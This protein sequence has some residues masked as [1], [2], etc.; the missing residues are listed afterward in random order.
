MT[1]K[2]VSTPMPMTKGALSS[3]A[4]YRS[5]IL[6]IRWAN[7]AGHPAQ[8]GPWL[9]RPHEV[10]G[11]EGRSS[12]L[13]PAADKRPK[14]ERRHRRTPR[15]HGDD[16]QGGSHDGAHQLDSPDGGHTREGSKREPAPS[17]P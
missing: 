17:E 2:K 15:S 10:W 16:S 5:R 8:D 12:S 11:R 3:S 14:A 9:V 7:S 13:P 1:R 4:T 6:I